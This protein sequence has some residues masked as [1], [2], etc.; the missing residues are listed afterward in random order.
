MEKKTATSTEY[1]EHGA[2]GG[3]KKLQDV[4]KPKPWQIQEPEKAKIIFLSYDANWDKD[5]EDE[6]PEFF[7]E[8]IEEYLTDGVKYVENNWEKNKMIHTP[9]LKDFYKGG[10]GRKYHEK[11]QKLFKELDFT[12][13]DVKDVC[14]LEL[15]NV[16]T[17]GNTNM[18]KFKNMLRR[19]EN[20]AH[21]KKIRKI[22]ES[23]KFIYTPKGVKNTI[24]KDIELKKYDFNTE[25][26]RDYTHLSYISSDDFNRLKIELRTFLGKT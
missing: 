26:I 10:N 9:M 20:V 22:F 1:G 4:F 25:N 7:K 23:E 17:Y 2:D 12:L 5:V 14:F 3:S 8:T 6:R 16:C 19:S 13:N 18:G 24:I 21:L 15:L 11:C